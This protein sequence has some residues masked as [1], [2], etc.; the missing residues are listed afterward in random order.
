MDASNWINLGILCVAVIAAVV[1][2]I[3]VVE[4]RK[5]RSD[6]Q[7]ARDKAGEHEAAA[8][9]AAEQS[10]ASATDSAASQ[11]R[12]ADATEEHTALLKAQATPHQDW[13]IEALTDASMD[14]K[15]RAVNNTGEVVRYVYVLTPTNT[16]EQWIVPDH[17]HWQ[18]VEPDE[19]VGFTFRRRHT[20]PK[21]VTIVIR[22]TTAANSSEARTFSA[23]IR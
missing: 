5:A 18:N 13:I 22:W 6:A 14:Q 1:A 16:D 9:R 7:D 12:I 17:D 3:Q 21:A 19:G 8:L 20:S 11:R 2:I 23:T 15:W 4:A 10:A